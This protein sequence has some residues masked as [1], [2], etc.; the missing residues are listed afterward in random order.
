MARVL[1]LVAVGVII[2]SAA[3]Y[4]AV[5]LTRKIPPVAATATTISET[6]PGTTSTLRWPSQ[7]EAAI[8]LRGS[9]LLAEHGAQKATPLASLTKLMTAYVVLHDHPLATTAIGPSITV[10]AADVATY[11]TEKAQGDSVVAVKAGEQ[12]SELDALEGM[13]IPSG[14][15]IADLLAT[16][17]AGSLQAFVAKMNAAA[18]SL[19]LTDTHYA[20]ASGVT[21]GSEST[22][23]SQVRLAMADMAIPAFRTIVAMP[24]V[25]LPVAGVGYNVDAELGKHGIVGIKTGWTP[26]AGGCFVFAAHEQIGGTSRTVVGAVLHQQ[27]TVTQLS[28]LTEAF[29]ASTALLTSATHTIVHDDVI[30]AGETIGHVTAPWASPVSLRASRGAAFIAMPGERFRATVH[31]T[32]QVDP[33]VGAHQRMGTV[34]VRLGNKQVTVPL[35]TSRALP[36]VS[37]RWRLTHV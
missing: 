14:D 4:T 20:D 1:V 27:A 19:G 15:N 17:D 18:T 6:V 9:G 12:L 2:L 25:T 37:L 31:L 30:H 23:A 11:Q 5:A 28:A 24:Q 36:A 35:V 10:T 3:A 32:R 16:W 29:D 33:P 7:G 34:V 21:P 13:L 26:A 8:G 22:A